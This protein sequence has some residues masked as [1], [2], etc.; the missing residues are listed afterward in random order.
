MHREGFFHSLFQAACRAGI[1]SLQLPEDFLQF[2]LGCGVVGHGVGVADS[3]VVVTLRFLGQILF[4][5]AA[6]VQLAALHFCAVAEDPFDGRAQRLGSIDH[7]QIAAFRA[8]PASHYIF[9]QV[10]HHGGVLRGALPQ[11]QH[12]LLARRFDAQRDNQHL[13]A[14]MN[15]VDPN[16]HQVQFV[17][18]SLTELFQLR[19]AGLYELP[20]HAR[21]LN[22][23]AV[24]HALHGPAMVAR[25][26]PR[27]DPFAYRTLP[28]PV[29]L[30]S[31]VTLQRN[32]LPLAC[33]HP[34]TAKRHLLPA[35]HHVARLLSPTPA[36]RRSVGLIAWPLASRHF[37]LDHRPND[38]QP[39]HP[40]QALNFRLQLFPY[41]HPRQWH[42]H[43]QLPVSHKLKL[44][45]GLAGRSLIDFSHSGSTLKKSFQ[46]E[47]YPSSGREPLLPCS[48]FN[49]AR[50]NFSLLVQAASDAR[51]GRKP[52]CGFGCALV[53][54]RKFLKISRWN[55]RPHKRRVFLSDILKAAKAGRW[56][57]CTARAAWIWIEIFYTGSQK[58]STYTRRYCLATAIAKNA[59]NFA[60]C[61]ISRCIH[62]TLSP[63]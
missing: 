49:Y 48:D 52:A 2:R 9:Q 54:R 61:S 15:P 7:E 25:A 17:Q 41:F 1:D 37:V 59:P 45:L 10:F 56:F 24:Q 43:R 51:L 6:L 4:D 21:F 63:P 22:A 11:P 47:L 39:G 12:V 34:R 46:L 53:G 60:T 28:P 23:V 18:F 8:Q 29:L 42:I 16:G 14:K 36:I 3:A 5:V 33:A 55:S 20:A 58:S 57:S 50:G 19:S 26:Q 35:K 40:G 32:F 44:L 30:Q 62:G 13:F 27:D 31:C 38:L